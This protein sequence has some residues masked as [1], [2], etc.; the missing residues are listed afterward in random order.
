MKKTPI[1]LDGD[2]GHDDAIAWVYAQACGAFDIRAVTS[3]AGN[4]TIEKVTFNARRICALAGIAAPIA[5]GAHRP[6]L[7]P[8]ISGSN[9]HGESGLDGPALPKPDRPLDQRTA[10]ELMADVLRESKEAV[11]IIATG[12][13]TNTAALLLAHPELK[14]KIAQIAI[15]GGGIRSGNWTP[16]A[17]YNIIEDPEAAQI[18]FASG[19]PILM[20]G[21]DVTERALIYP[22]DQKK[23]AAVGNQVGDIVAGWLKFFF[24]HHQ[25]LGW[26]GSPL[27]DPCAVMGLVHPEIFTFKQAHVCVDTHGE[28]TRGAT[29]IEQGKS[30]D[31]K[32]MLDVDREKFVQ[33]L[34]EACR[35]YDGREVEIDG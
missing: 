11:T 31:T 22:E 34:V 13:Q 9:F 28:F 1:I 24:I 20:A 30:L 35:V 25:E 10:V 16:A 17:E 3:V 18:V 12:P 4:Q 21:L 26:A 29:I 5:E 14:N 23:F 27:H 15:M 8:Y 33:Y 6:L 2:P 19:L 7:C 32:I